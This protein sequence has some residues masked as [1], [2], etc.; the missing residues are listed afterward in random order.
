[1]VLRMAP[2]L[3]SQVP[4]LASPTSNPDQLIPTLGG[5]YTFDI[6]WDGVRC[7]AYI[8]DG[9]VMLRNRNGVDITHRYPDIATM[10][11]EKYPTGQ[12][13][14]DG[15]LLCFN[16]E[17]G[18]PEFAR[19]A[20]RD[21]QSHSTKIELIS[22]AMPATFMAFD[23]L[24]FDGDDLRNTALAGRL[25]LLRAEADAV[26]ANDPRLMVSQWSDD[27]QLLWKFVCDFGMEGLIAK[28]KQG[29]YRGRRDGGWLKLKKLHRLTAIVTGYEQ[30]K[31]ARA[32]K[33][34]ALFLALRNDQG[35]LVPIG[36]VGTGL[37]DAD[38]APML[39]ILSKPGCM[40]LAEV[41]YMEFTKDGIL[42][43]PSFK[44]VRSDLTSA[45]C[46]FQQLEQR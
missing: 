18:K 41:E 19:A 14:F 43:F 34:G 9:R 21:A 20:K 32:G 4:M 35:E 42:R 33:I 13:V 22:K 38:H 11:A 26:F 25:A 27:G 15:E 23:Y 1:M 24:W 46:T 2:D 40:F 36:K 12:R 8:D 29:V 7:L 28:D 16:P 44:G 5:R 17:T 30:G 3:L 31:G 39:D 6:K 37:K 45:D 10:L